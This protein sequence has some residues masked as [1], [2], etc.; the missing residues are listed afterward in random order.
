MKGSGKVGR[1]NFKEVF[2]GVYGASD[3]IA[4]TKRF[5]AIL[6]D[7][8]EQI[9]MSDANLARRFILFVTPPPLVSYP[10]TRSMS[11]ITTE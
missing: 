8:V 9:N 2:D 7:N 11:A 4:M 10:F 6:V 5:E 3:F 1:V